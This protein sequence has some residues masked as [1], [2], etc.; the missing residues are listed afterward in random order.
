M[1]THREVYK[2]VIHDSDTDSDIGDDPY[3]EE[4]LGE[5]SAARIRDGVEKDGTDASASIG[6]RNI[7]LTLHLIDRSF[8]P[9]KSSLTRIERLPASD[10]HV[11]DVC[12]GEGNQTFRWLALMSRER[13][14]RLYR[15]RGISRQRE[16]TVGFA[17]S[18]IPR[19]VKSEDPQSDWEFLAPGAKLNS[20]LIDGDHLWM[21]YNQ[22]GAK[23]TGWSASAF[24]D[25]EH[26]VFNADT[27]TGG[28][29]T[30]EG[31]ETAQQSGN[32]GDDGGISTKQS[33]LNA[34]MKTP[35]SLVKL[36]AAES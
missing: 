10:E 11:I 18:F 14:E 35:E 2:H 17:A 4:Y 36:P 34:G 9:C 12:I 16:R 6:R 13:L 27:S 15:P 24:V 20:V 29:G 22:D 25:I 8:R 5:S 33:S 30:Q 31:N 21:E 26:Q 19:S 28:M 1:F 3:S 7:H 32:G 23:Y